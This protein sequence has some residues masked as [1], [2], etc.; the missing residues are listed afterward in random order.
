MCVPTVKDEL[1]M[2]VKEVMPHLPRVPADF[3]AE[4]LLLFSQN[5]VSN[6]MLCEGGGAATF[7][8]QVL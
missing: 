7:L 2:E 6:W 4:G 1:L 8:P 5:K 3:A